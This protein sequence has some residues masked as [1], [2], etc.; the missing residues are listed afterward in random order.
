MRLPCTHSFSASPQTMLRPAEAWLRKGLSTDFRHVQ[1][2]T[3]FPSDGSPEPFRT[4]GL[5]LLYRMPFRS[6]L[7][8]LEAFSRT[9]P[10]DCPQTCLR[11]AARQAATKSLSI[12]YFIRQTEISHG[13]ATRYAA[14]VLSRKMKLLEKSLGEETKSSSS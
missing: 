14:A 3:S 4:A 5:R 6:R 7:V 10:A 8:P 9:K 11:H 2:I 13:Q 12:L 1:S